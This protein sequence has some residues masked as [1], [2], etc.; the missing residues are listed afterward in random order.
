MQPTRGQFEAG[1]RRGGTVPASGRAAGE[2]AAGRCVPAHRHLLT[3]DDEPVHVVQQID[4]AE[5]RGG[6]ASSPAGQAPGRGR[7]P[8]QARS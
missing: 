1:G 3:C 4:V 2:W 7:A 8:R 5:H 6:R